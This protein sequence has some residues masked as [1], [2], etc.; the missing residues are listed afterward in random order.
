MKI[1]K[2]QDVIF[3]DGIVDFNQND[4]IIKW[5]VCENTVVNSLVIEGNNPIP[6][7]GGKDKNVNLSNMCKSK[8]V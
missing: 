7:L 6:N 5:K 3:Y 8:E 1:S 2:S 4:G